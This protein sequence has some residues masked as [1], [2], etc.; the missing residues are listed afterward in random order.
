M[1]RRSGTR[2]VVRLESKVLVVSVNVSLVDVGV[3]GSGD[4]GGMGNRNCW[5][6]VVGSERRRVRV[7]VAG[8]GVGGD[9]SSSSS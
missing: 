2:R 7:G 8:S 9:A 5:L 6:G 3:G 4:S 1:I